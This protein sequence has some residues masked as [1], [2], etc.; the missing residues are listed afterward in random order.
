MK[1]VGEEVEEEE[2]RAEVEEE[3]VVVVVE[4][5]EPL[6]PMPV[7]NVVGA[8]LYALTSPAT[9]VWSVGW[10]GDTAVPSATSGSATPTTSAPTRGPSTPTL[11][12]RPRLLPRPHS[13]RET[14]LGFVLWKKSGELFS[15]QIIECL[16]YIIQFLQA[17]VIR[18]KP[19]Y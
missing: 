13:P 11:P 14:I 16:S 3:E 7:Q 2:G 5:E 9:C 18:D 12:P 17:L 19:Y 6:P 4:V 10:R 1:V 15:I 8:T